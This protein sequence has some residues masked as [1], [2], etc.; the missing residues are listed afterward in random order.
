MVDQIDNNLNSNIELMVYDRMLPDVGGH[1]TAS[2]NFI[3]HMSKYYNV[4]AVCRDAVPS[5]IRQIRQYAKYVPYTGQK[6]STDILVYNSSWGGHPD[7]ITCKNAAIYMLHANYKE[8]YKMS[9][10]KYT[11]PANPVKHIAVS[12][13]VSEAFEDM[14]NIKSQVIPNMLD[15]EIKVEKV[16]RLITC[17]R[18]TKEKG[19]D[20]IV[21]MAEMLTK[22][23]KKFIWFIYGN[24]EMPPEIKAYP[25]IIM[26]GVS[27][28][29][30]SYTADCD[31]LVHLS[32]TEGDAYCTKEALQ[33]NTP[34]IT[35]AY[36]STYEQITDGYNGYILDFELFKTGTDEQWAN[37]INKIYN[38]IPKFEYKDKDP[39][40]EKQWIKLLGEPIGVKKA[41]IPYKEKQYR[42]IATINFQDISCNI[43]R[44]PTAIYKKSG[45]N[46][47]VVDEDRYYLLIEH[48]YI[49]LVDIIED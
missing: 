37:V 40:I 6:L 30:P 19:L 11:A 43:L 24:G 35:T 28:D 45:D 14:Y 4:T 8:V 21:K 2:L 27:H 44:T 3:K 7:T 34:C 12:K 10:F 41:I 47:W 15:P 38:K 25:N 17:S 1:A 9:K 23:K 42:V 46:T 18:L 31:Y 5:R 39:E 32:Y 48:K 13:H 16:L 29:L 20:N 26:M 49:K 33:V 22:F 36:P